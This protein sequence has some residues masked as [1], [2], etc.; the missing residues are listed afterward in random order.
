VSPEVDADT[1]RR[2]INRRDHAKPELG[3]ALTSTV[4]LTT[5][6]DIAPNGPPDASPR[7]RA[8]VALEVPLHD[9]R[10]RRRRGRALVQ[11][12][13]RHEQ[14]QLDIRRFRG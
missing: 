3:L 9:H 1:P 4:D 7:S 13:N 12:K 11:L 14:R 5:A 6:G 10:H 2:H 8:P